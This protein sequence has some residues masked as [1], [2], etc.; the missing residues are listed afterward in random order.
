VEAAALARLLS[1]WAVAAAVLCRAITATPPNIVLPDIVGSVGSLNTFVALVGHSGAGKDAAVSTAADAVDFGYQVR[2]RGIGTGQGIMGQFVKRRKVTQG[3]GD[4]RLETYENRQIEDRLLIHIS[5]IHGLKSSAGQ[6]G[7]NILPVLADAWT[8][9]LLGGTY[10]DE[11]LDI[12][13]PAHG[14]RLGVIAGVQPGEAEILTRNDSLGLPQRFVWVPAADVRNTE[15][16]IPSWPGSLAVALPDVGPPPSELDELARPG[17]RQG[18]RVV[19]GV[20]DQARQAVINDR[21]ARQHPDF[22]GD[23][24]DSHVL[25]CRLKIAA[26]LALMETRTDITEEDWQ[27]S[28]VIMLRSSSTRR[29]VFGHLTKQARE[30]EA[31]RRLEAVATTVAAETARNDAAV[32]RAMLRMITVLSKKG[33]QMRRS[34]LR[35]EAGSAYRDHF[36][37]ALSQLE[38]D[39]T[40]KVDEAQIEIVKR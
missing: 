9:A 3:E 39:G 29:A 23:P 6:Q 38:N 11:K 37:D 31:A 4:D 22:Q 34:D 28:G 10:K 17:F 20:C 18:E 26:G 13:V 32:R 27:L 19:M 2:K 36:E 7:A 14:Y 40:I 16:E 15:G 5:E 21:R 33:P 8:G 30:A 25:F 24:L 12:E 1:P 35:R